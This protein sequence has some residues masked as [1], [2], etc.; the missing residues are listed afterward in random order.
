MRSVLCERGAKPTLRGRMPRHCRRRT[1]PVQRQ[2]LRALIILARPSRGIAKITPASL[3]EL[4]GGGDLAL[5]KTLSEVPAA[6]A[7]SRDRGNLPE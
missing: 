1:P 3:S 6:I 4:I 2:R 5:P 7:F